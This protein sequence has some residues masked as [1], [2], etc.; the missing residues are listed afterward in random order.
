MKNKTKHPNIAACI[1]DIPDF[2]KK[3][4]VFKDIT[5]LLANAAAFHDCIV[6]L[7]AQLPKNTDFIVGMESRGFLFGAALAMHT[8]LGFIPIRKPGK[9]PHDVHTIEYELEYGVDQLEVHQD[10]L[11][12]H[13]HVVIIDDLLATGGTASATLHLIRKL[14]ATPIAALFVIELDFLQGRERLSDI[15]VYSLLHY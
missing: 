2:P 8:G 12:D 7:A 13:H 15:P 9:L 3:G 11:A 14:G 10:A 5:P 4:I 1:R 6:A